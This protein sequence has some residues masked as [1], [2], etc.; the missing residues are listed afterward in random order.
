MNR[1]ANFTVQKYV[2]TDMRGIMKQVKTDLKA[3]K[4]I[5]FHRYG[6]PCRRSF[7]YLGKD[8]EN[9]YTCDLIC[10]GVPSPMLLE[11]YLEYVK[12]SEKSDI[13]KFF[14]SVIIT[15]R[16]AIHGTIRVQK[17]SS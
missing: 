14:I 13:E 11:K 9:L 16:K 5:T 10:H 4:T 8:F 15:Q 6:M 17:G 3:G 7:K 1:R 12:K 2:Q